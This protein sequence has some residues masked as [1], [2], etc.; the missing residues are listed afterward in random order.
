MVEFALEFRLLAA[1]D[2]WN[3]PAL[4]VAFRRVLNRNILTE[5]SCRDDEAT[6]NSL[7]DMDIHIGNLFLDR[8]SMLAGL[9]VSAHSPVEPMQLSN[10]HLSP[11]ERAQWHQEGLC[12]YY[13]QANSRI[14]QCTEWWRAQQHP[15]P[16]GVPPTKTLEV[17]SSVLLQIPLCYLTTMIK[18][19]DMISILPELIGRGFHGP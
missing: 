3:E 14:A 5:I 1:E 7:I 18:Y 15:V 10:S 19:S 13:R 6:L 8:C 4:N 16:T 11:I 2:G 17:S 9:P 12:F